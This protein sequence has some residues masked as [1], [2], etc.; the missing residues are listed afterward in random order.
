MYMYI[1]AGVI[2]LVGVIV[3]QATVR[4]KAPLGGYIS[5]TIGNMCIFQEVTSHSNTVATKW[6]RRKMHARLHSRLSGMRCHLPLVT[7]METLLP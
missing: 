7:S 3:A 5:Y 4:S 2:V 1:V 6:R